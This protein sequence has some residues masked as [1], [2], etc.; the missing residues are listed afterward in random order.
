M[1]CCFTP[2]ARVGV[3]GKK[4]VRVRWWGRASSAHVAEEER[5]IARQVTCFFALV[6]RIRGWSHPPRAAMAQGADSGGGDGRWAHGDGRR[7]AERK[8]SGGSG[9]SGDGRCPLRRATATRFVER[10]HC[11]VLGWLLG[12]LTHLSSAELQT[13]QALLVPLG[14][15][16]SGSADGSHVD[17]P[18]GYTLW[19]GVILQPQKKVKEQLDLET[20]PPFPLSCFSADARHRQCYLAARCS[21]FCILYGA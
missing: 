7:C 16:P 12:A 9:H 5:N 8:R 2:A 15:H 19:Q 10:A 14:A 6:R 20:L 17:G 3:V 18:V 11:V 21:C 13:L 1:G 4:T